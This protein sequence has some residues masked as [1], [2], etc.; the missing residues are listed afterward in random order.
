MR[1]NSRKIE[2]FQEVS[3][4]FIHSKTVGRGFESSC[5]C[6]TEKSVAKATGFSV[7]H[8]AWSREPDTAKRCT[9]AMFG[10][11]ALQNA[12]VDRKTNLQR[13]EAEYGILLPIDI[14]NPPRDFHFPII[15]TLPTAP[16][17]T[18]SKKQ[19]PYQQSVK[20]LQGEYRI[21][22]SVLALIFVYCDAIFESL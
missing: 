8:K 15:P 10:V 11:F 22:V 21:F 13:S 3:G 1:W 9:G 5:P 2:D 12:V 6:Q 14:L 17:A 19:Q 4:F 18:A 7:W 20:K 16:F